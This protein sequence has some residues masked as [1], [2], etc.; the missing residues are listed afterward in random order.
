MRTEAE[1]IGYLQQRFP[2]RGELRVGIGD[3]A[4]VLAGDARRDWVVTTDFLIEG[5]HFLRGAQ[6]ASAVGW[7]ALARS[8]S[9]IAA[10]GARARYALVA[11]AVPGATPTDWVKDF[12]AGVNRLARR[13]GVKLAG[14]DLSAAPQIV[15]DVQVLGEVEKRRALL[16]SGARPGETLFVSGTLGRSQ[17]GLA[18]LRRHTRPLRGLLKSARRAH[19]YPEPRLRLARA[20]VRRGG[21]SAL[22]DLSDGLS[23]DLAH[24]CKA[25][26]VG[27]RIFAK[28]IPA[29]RLPRTLA[30]RFGTNGLTLALDGG[31]DYE[32]LFTLP[33][34]R[35]ARLPN[36]LAGVKLT[37]IGEITPGRRLTLVD[38][39]GRERPLRPRGWDH[40]RRR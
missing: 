26:R 10:M 40:F 30:E 1:W 20:L 28:Q 3:D 12:F 14:G 11:L 8:L 6:P 33:K 36:K 21:V 22:I 16:R 31:E 37:P 39:A 4:A 27:A 2:A 23:T 17:L 32:L 34:A 18:V 9:D 19:C 29:V 15:T 25:S 24:L 7:K 38:A 5:V 35:A 13:Y